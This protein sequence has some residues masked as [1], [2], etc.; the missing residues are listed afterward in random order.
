MSQQTVSLK[1]S[2]WITVIAGAVVVA[3]IAA[4]ITRSLPVR[5]H[6]AG[7][8]LAKGEYM[9]AQQAF[10]MLGDY[11]DAAELAEEAEKGLAYLEAQELLAQGR[12]GE[13]L[14]LFETIGGFED[15]QDQ[16]TQAKYL[17]AVELTGQNKRKEARDLLEQ[18]G[19][20]RD[21]FALLEQL[22]RYDQ[23]W[24]YM[25]TERY[26]KA[27]EEFLALEDFLDAAQQANECRRLGEV[28]ETY[29]EGNRQFH[30]GKWLDAY[31]TL[32]LIHEEGYEDTQDILDEISVVARERVRL[33][34]EQGERGKMLAFLRLVEEIDEAAGAA[35][36]QELVPEEVFEEDWSYFQFDPAPLTACSSDTTGEEYAATLFDLIL[37]GEKELTLQADSPLNKADTLGQFYLGQNILSDIIPGYGLVYDVGINVQE[38]SVQIGLQYTDTYTEERMAQIIEIYDTF[39]KESL[40]ELFE[41]GLLSNSMNRIRKAVL[42]SEW[43]GFYLTYDDMKQI[44]LS[45]VAVEEAKGVCSAYA[46]LC[47]RMCN[48]VGVP[49]YG[50]T[51]TAYNPGGYGPHIWLIHVDESGEI[52]YSDPTWADPW[53]IDFSKEDERPTVEKFAEQYLERCLADGVREYRYPSTAGQRDTRYFCARALWGSHEADRTAEEIVATHEK[54]Q[55]KA[56]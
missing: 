45:G 8:M 21:A 27:E 51:G 52:F 46:S 26:D 39:C 24:A 40:R 13:A 32:F 44:R 25:V 3:V 4:A 1:K 10:A 50:Q 14:A 38:N 41:M 54:F 18:I 6:L 19:E 2:V 16:I 33:Y 37:R 53:D 56:S 29:W 34:A 43:V 31:R 55:G 47:H 11:K 28:K 23:A 49:T 20:Y 5:Y 7:A 36:R 17:L 12:Y 22:K 30:E 35:L 9:K 48:L 42:I 15:T